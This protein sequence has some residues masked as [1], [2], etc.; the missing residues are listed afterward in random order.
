LVAGSIPAIPTKLE[1][2]TLI[3]FITHTNY[4]FLRLLEE[5]RHSLL[6]FAADEIN[7]RYG[8]FVEC[9][10]LIIHSAFHRALA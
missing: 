7:D 3:S 2:S 10:E 4:S 1:F 8:E 9:L 5:V 6:A